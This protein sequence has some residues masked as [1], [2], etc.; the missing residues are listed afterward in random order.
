MPYRPLGTCLWY[1]CWEY[2][3]LWDTANLPINRYR[4][5]SANSSKTALHILDILDIL[6]NLEQQ[7]GKLIGPPSLRSKLMMW[8]GFMVVC[9]CVPPP[10][11]LMCPFSIPVSEYPWNNH[12]ILC[13]I[14]SRTASH[15]SRGKSSE[16]GSRK[17][18]GHLAPKWKFLVYNLLRETKGR[19]D[20]WLHSG[21]LEI[22]IHI[23]CRPLDMLP[24]LTCPSL[25]S[26]VVPHNE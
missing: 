20:E 4:R 1:P 10:S 22:W 24:G 2:C 6:D 13:R 19:K 3:R 25:F 16:V 9:V 21:D 23:E 11:C 18:S 15:Q 12:R 14:A 8:M 7:A 5:K 17:L 26:P